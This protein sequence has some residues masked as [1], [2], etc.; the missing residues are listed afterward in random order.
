MNQK[1]VGDIKVVQ[2]K[3]RI[4]IVDDYPIIRSVLTEFINLESDLEVCAMAENTSQALD[5][6]EKQPI[7][8]AVVDISLNGESGFELSE[9]IK[10]RW[11]NIPILIFSS[12]DELMY[13][14]RAF[15]VGASGYVVKCLGATKELLTAIRQVLA[16]KIYISEK[17]MENVPKKNIY[18]ILTE[19]DRD[20][21]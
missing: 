19:V 12:H 16:G 14:N 9:K 21:G 3:S 6:I 17:I 18:K 13:V 11:P 15:R 20:S 1:G 4:L 7:D 8:L 5:S 10:L 2:N